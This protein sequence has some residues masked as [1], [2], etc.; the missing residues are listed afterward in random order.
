MKFNE[1]KFYRKWK[2]ISKI[3]NVF[4]I[5]GLIGV[6][7]STILVITFIFWDQY[8]GLICAFSFIACA[9]VAIG[10]V[11]CRWNA[12]FKIFNYETHYTD[13]FC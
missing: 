1:Q 8:V 10:G 4:V 6:C 11:I 12:D 9:I 3:A 13:I 5:L 7:I 2:T